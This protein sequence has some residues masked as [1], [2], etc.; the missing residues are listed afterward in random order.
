MVRKCCIF[1]ILFASMFACAPRLRAQSTDAQPEK[2]VPPDT[3]NSP[4]DKTQKNTDDLF[5]IDMAVATPDTRPLAGAQA[6]TLGTVTKT[7]NFLLPSFSVV[8]QGQISPGASNPSGVPDTSFS[9]FAAGRVAMNHVSMN[10]SILLDYLAGGSFPDKAALGSSVIQSLDFAYS[11]QRKRW[12]TTLGESFTYTSAAPFGYGGLG[13]LDSLGIGLGNG[14]GYSTGFLPNFIPDQSLFLDGAPRISN[15]VIGQEDYAL[16]HRS[17]LTFSTS[18]GLLKFIN[19]GFE[20]GGGVSFQAGYNYELSRKNTISLAYQFSR[21]S[22][23]SAPTKILDHSAL[24]FYGRR[25]TGRMSFQVSAGP[26][27][28][29]Y[30]DAVNNTGTSVSWAMYSVLNYQFGRT[31]LAGSYSR[32]QT[33]GSGLFLGAE[34]DTVSGSAT[35]KFNRNWDG[36]VNVG[37][38][39][40]QS[41]KQTTPAENLST[42]AAWFTTG[43]LTR[44]FLRFGSL[45][46]SYAFSHQSSLAGL[47]TLPSCNGSTNSHAI[48]IG[49]TWGL[50]PLLL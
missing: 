47:C 49:Y 46:F 20:D 50:H 29:T 41:L 23:F 7:Y 16:S 39:R 40:T 2:P 5:P 26:Q 21:F 27:I 30:H 48:S 19:A 31:R 15:A 4:G 28:A 32:S 17:S 38:A 22:F 37:Y 10:S 14:L 45:F 12:T 9:G 8:A 35:Q 18:Y 44:H 24:V 43:Q 3:L 1:S 25:V 33:G 36:S 34:T 11:T 6:I 42:P 13:G